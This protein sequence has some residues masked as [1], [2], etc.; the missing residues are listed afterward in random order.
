[1]TPS[2]GGNTELLYSIHLNRHSVKESFENRDHGD[3]GRNAQGVNIL[4]NRGQM[5]CFREAILA[6]TPKA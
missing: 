4:I 1:M 2:K 6:E 3:S 5:I